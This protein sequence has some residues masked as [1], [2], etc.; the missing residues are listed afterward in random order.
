MVV[1]DS[2]KVG[3]A[4]Y[5]VLFAHNPEGVLISTPDGRITAANPAA[6][7][8]LDLSAEEICRLGGDAIFDQEDPRWR[9]AV[10]ERDRTGSSVSVARVRRGD[11][12]YIEIETT[13]RVF[14]GE[15]GAVQILHLLHDISRR[16]AIEREVEE[17]S[18]RLLELSHG[19]EL[20][21]FHN[22]RGLISSGTR[23]LQAADRQA[24]DVQLLYVDVGNVQELNQRLGHRAGDAALQAV[25][26]ALRVSFRKH[27]VLAR[28]GGTEFLVLAFN[29][30]EPESVAIASHIRHH[31][32]APDTTAFVGGEVEVAFGW[33]TRPAGDPASLEDLMARADS[34]IREARRACHPAGGPLHPAALWDDALP[35][36]A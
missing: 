15:G 30:A 33:T 13:A 23:L 9:L 10:A 32:A 27:D 11:G 1:Q 5:Q 16:V 2:E 12:R 7:A 29:L 19:D 26:R 21:G 18:A 24:V 28:I 14:H 35:A 8:L 22:R 6:C 3:L 17:L 36:Q 31:L 20:T 25:A 34:A 4:A